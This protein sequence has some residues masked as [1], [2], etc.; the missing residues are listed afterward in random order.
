VKE[1]TISALEALERMKRT[2]AEITQPTWTP[3]VT[4]ASPVTHVTQND[5]DELFETRSDEDDVGQPEINAEPVIEE[6]P[7]PFVAA[8]GVAE[9][10]SALADITAILS[11]KRKSGIGHNP[12]EGD[13]TLKRRLE[14]LKM[15]LWDYVSMSKWF[16][17]SLKTAHA[18]QKGP[19]LACNLCDWAR[20]FIADRDNLLYNLYGAWNVSMLDKGE[21]V[22]DIHLHLQGIS[23]YVK[24]MD[25]V[26]FLDTTEIKEKYSLKKPSR[27]PQHNAGCI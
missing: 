18:F 9:A 11:P 8:P 22:K 16:L 24:A 17:A 27:L 7:N 23:K 1:Q 12:F 26:N 3:S 10:K 14:M 13:A 4:E 20:S 15:F 19:H 25:I 6:V 21:L 5:N 2:F